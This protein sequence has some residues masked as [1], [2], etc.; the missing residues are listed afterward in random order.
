MRA[1]VRMSV[2]V[3]LMR[4]C[5]GGWLTLRPAHQSLHRFA[6]PTICGMCHGCNVFAAALAEPVITDNVLD[7]QTRSHT[8]HH[9]L[10]ALCST[11]ILPATACTMFAMPENTVL[12]QPVQPT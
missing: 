7:G 4:V 8:P 10:P 2:H 5:M 9:L 11:A 1:R 3:C 6:H 12:L